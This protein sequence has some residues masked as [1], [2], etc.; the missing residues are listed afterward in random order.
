MSR[1]GRL[2]AGGFDRVLYAVFFFN[3]LSVYFSSVGYALQHKVLRGCRPAGRAGFSIHAE[4]VPCRWKTG[5]NGP[6]EDC[7]SM[8]GVA[9]LKLRLWSS[10]AVLGTARSPRFA[11]RRPA[12][13]ER[14]V[15]G[16]Q[17]CWKYAGPAPR[18]QLNARNAVSV[19]IR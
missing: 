6:E 2:E 15:V 7:P 3:Q 11:E 18:M 9:A 14:F 8:T 17:T 16:M 12:R 19:R 10:V 1:A 4:T 13:R 5:A